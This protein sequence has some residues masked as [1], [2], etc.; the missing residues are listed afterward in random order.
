MRKARESL[1]LFRQHRLNNFPW[2]ETTDA[3]REAIEAAGQAI[4]D[5]RAQHPGATLADL[6]DPLT[7]PAELRKAHAA[8][9]RAVDAAYGY[10]GDKLDAARV[11]YLFEQYQRLTSLL[12]GERV[13]IG[14]K[15]A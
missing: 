7:M 14:R 3:Q 10:R 9:D 1:P 13:K 2:P 4:L 5:A 11:A 15:G 8:N 6:Y 12:P